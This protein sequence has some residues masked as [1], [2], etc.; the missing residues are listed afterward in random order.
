VRASVTDAF[1]YNFRVIVPED[2]VYDRAPTSH[3]V[4]LWDMNGKYADVMPVDAVMDVIGRV[5]A[6]A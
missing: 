1:A 4:N 5:E 3:A 6:P 2:A